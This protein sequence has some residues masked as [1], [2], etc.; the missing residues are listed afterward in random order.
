M[1]DADSGDIIA[2]VLTDQDAGDAITNNNSKAAVIIPP[3]ANTV[4]CPRDYPPVHGTGTSRKSTPMAGRVAGG[5][6][7]L[8]VEHRSPTAA[9]L[10]RSTPDGVAIVC[11]ILNRMP[12]CAR[13][14]TV[15]CKTVGA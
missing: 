12:A 4:E 13:P 14:R 2:H 6:R 8:Q 15:G 5:D 10:S 1:L 7:S 3:H 9:T 11:T